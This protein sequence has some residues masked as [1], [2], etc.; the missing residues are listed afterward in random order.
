MTDKDVQ[1]LIEENKELKNEL[2]QRKQS[3]EALLEMQKAF[4]GLANNY[5][6]FIGKM[7]KLIDK[8]E[9][10]IDLTLNQIKDNGGLGS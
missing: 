10:I 9:P 3:D 7:N 1:K 8:C 2:Y 6:E 5:S 4:T